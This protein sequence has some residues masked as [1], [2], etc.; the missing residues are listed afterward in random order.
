MRYTVTVESAGEIIET[1]PDRPMFEAQQIAAQKA[2]Q[3]P[4]RKVFVEFFRR[5]DG[6]KGYLN[7]DGNHS[8]T[9][10]AW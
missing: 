7:P 6:Q 2:A 10:K 1:T 5:Y 9:G 4:R 3:Y 8:I